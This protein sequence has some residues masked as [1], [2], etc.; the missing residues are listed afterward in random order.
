MP[1]GTIEDVCEILKTDD[2]MGWRACTIQE[3]QAAADRGQAAIG[4]SNR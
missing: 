1:V 3:A 4:I 2:Y